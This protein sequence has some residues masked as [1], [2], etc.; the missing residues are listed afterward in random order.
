MADNGPKDTLGVLTGNVSQRR[1]HDQHKDRYQA[2]TWK[3]E[4]C[5]HRHS[6]E[7]G[8]D[9]AGE[10][11]PPGV[12]PVK[13]RARHPR[14]ADRAAIGRKISDKV[15]IIKWLAQTNKKSAEEWAKTLEEMRERGEKF[16]KPY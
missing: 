6:L 4:E 1:R 5:G 11:I 12:C 14:S 2:N 16:P 8:H 15:R 13:I 7:G 3:C 9:Q 10:Y